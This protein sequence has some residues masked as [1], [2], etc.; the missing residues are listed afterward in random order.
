VAMQKAVVPAAA[1]NFVMSTMDIINVG[2]PHA[3]CAAFTV[4]REQ[5]VPRMFVEVV[6]GIEEVGA[7][8][9]RLRYYL[10]RHIEVDGDKHG[11]VSLRMLENLCGDAID[12]WFDATGTAVVALQARKRLWDAISE[13]MT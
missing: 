3:V 7:T 6:R 2:R 13:L 5:A 10:E 9:T 11:P 4:G 1:R 8:T 12:R